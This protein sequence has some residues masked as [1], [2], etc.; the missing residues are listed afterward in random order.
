MVKW[1]EPAK[2]DL[3]ILFE[4]I[5]RDSPHYAKKVTQEI[6]AK[7]DVLNERHAEDRQGRPRDRRRT[8][9]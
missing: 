4:Y 5:S 6:V 2:A 8:R 7:V 1:S 3:R 9:P